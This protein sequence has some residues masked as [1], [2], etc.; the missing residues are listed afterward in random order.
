M[1]SYQKRKEEIKEL[2]KELEI[3]QALAREIKHY[4]LAEA[5]GQ[6][7]HVEQCKRA[8]LKRVPLV[9]GISEREKEEIGF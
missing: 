4:F 8:V 2:K 3:A 7:Q 6:E 9:C 1:T 5:R